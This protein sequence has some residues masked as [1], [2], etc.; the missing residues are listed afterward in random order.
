MGT[1]LRRR[2]DKPSW[3]NVRS[4]YAP[5]G[6][7]LSGS[8]RMSRERCSRR[9]S[10]AYHVRGRGYPGPRTT[11]PGLAPVCSPFLMTWT[12]FTITWTTP[13]AYWCGC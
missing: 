10:L 6:G 1:V 2:G 8:R 3:G 9:W 12:P 5:V 13:V 11:R 7:G 4:R